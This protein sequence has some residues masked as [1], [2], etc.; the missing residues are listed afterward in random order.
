[1]SDAEFAR[2]PSADEAI[3]DS[4]RSGEF[5]LFYRA[6]VQQLVGFLMMHGASLADAT[7]IAQD[8]LSSAYERWHKLDNPRAWSYR[9]ASRALIRKFVSTKEN[10]TADAIEPGSVLRA[11]PADAWHE[12]HELITALARLPTR[13]RQVM[14][15]RLSGYTPLEIAVELGIT[16]DAVRSN[17]YLARRA[18][19]VFL[20]G[21]EGS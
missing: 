10:L 7:D 20:N 6:T 2:R 19:D 8:T 12:R 16:H 21:G 11:T 5:E 18:I 4:A 3:P 13:Q 17:L 1:M 15:W 14:A 9:V